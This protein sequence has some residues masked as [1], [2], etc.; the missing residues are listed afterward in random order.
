MEVAA[1]V[2]PRTHLTGYVVQTIF[3]KDTIQMEMSFN[4]AEHHPIILMINPVVVELLSMMTK[5]SV[6]EVT[7]WTK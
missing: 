5:R 1:K 7:Q 6:V 4:V 2:M 3:I